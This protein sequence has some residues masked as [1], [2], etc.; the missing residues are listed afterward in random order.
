MAIAKVKG[1]TAAVEGRK[2]RKCWMQGFGRV[3]INAQ[4]G[5][6]VVHRDTGLHLRGDCL[7]HFVTFLSLITCLE[8]GGKTGHASFFRG[9][10]V[11]VSFSRWLGFLR[12]G[13]GGSR[14]LRLKQR[15]LSDGS[16]AGLLERAGAI[17]NWKLILTTSDRGMLHVWRRDATVKPIRL[18]QCIA[19]EL[20]T[21]R[22]EVVAAASPVGRRLL[23][24]LAVELI[25]RLLG[26]S[27]GRSA[28]LGLRC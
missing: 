1:R 11:G 5:G 10:Q 3:E 16:L 24:A 8:N 18:T 23:G 13:W 4:F 17:A 12:P 15:S 20:A 7:V 21:K 26:R 27:C 2:G 6:I 28:L 25:D 9:G 22:R 19:V 14:L